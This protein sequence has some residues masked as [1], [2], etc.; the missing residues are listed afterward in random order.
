MSSSGNERWAQTEAKIEALRRKLNILIEEVEK[1]RDPDLRNQTLGRIESLQ[2]SIERLDSKKNR[3]LDRLRLR[4]SST[5]INNLERDYSELE[6]EYKLVSQ[7]LRDETH[8]F[9]RRAGLPPINDGKA[10]SALDLTAS[11]SSSARRGVL[12]PS[13]SLSSLK[14]KFIRDAAARS[15]NYLPYGFVPPAND[16]MPTQTSDSYSRPLP[17]N[18]NPPQNNWSGPYTYTGH[19]PPYRQNYVAPP[20]GY[21]PVTRPFPPSTN[22]PQNNPT[23]AEGLNLYTSPTMPHYS[24]LQVNPTTSQGLGPEFGQRLNI[25]GGG[26]MS[27]IH[28]LGQ[29]PTNFIGVNPLGMPTGSQVHQASLIGQ[30]IQNPNTFPSHV[31]PN[32]AFLHNQPL[33]RLAQD[34]ERLQFGSSSRNFTPLSPPPRSLNVIAPHQPH[35]PHETEDAE[36]VDD[37]PIP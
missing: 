30:R 19:S 18:A 10:A 27:N 35:S 6:S 28:S 33:A 1:E 31:I 21:N 9:E 26:Y 20:L 15:A 4:N 37:V 5:V 8:N 24:Q 36:G 32:P 29:N 25:P 17:P 14:S 22:Y 2:T 16:L 3:I 11:A 34:S 23:V 13:T 12:N 7:K